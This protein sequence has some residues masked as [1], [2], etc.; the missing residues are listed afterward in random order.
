MMLCDSFKSLINLFREVHG[1]Y[2]HNTSTVSIKVCTD[3]QNNGSNFF[4]AEDNALVGEIVNM[5]IKAIKF[6]CKL[7]KLMQG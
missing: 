3:I 7:M 2:D 6:K 4:E 5:G 1:P